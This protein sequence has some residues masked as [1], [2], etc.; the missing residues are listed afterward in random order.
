MDRF[1]RAG[2]QLLLSYVRGEEGG[3]R[4]LQIYHQAS[5]VMTVSFFLMEG[6]RLCRDVTP[7][8]LDIPEYFDDL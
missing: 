8:Q 7:E 4:I 2:G 3:R 6:R 1:Q 5:R